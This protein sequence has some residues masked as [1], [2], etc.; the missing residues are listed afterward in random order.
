MYDRI[1]D[2]LAL[3]REPG[4]L[5]IHLYASSQDGDGCVGWGRDW[6]TVAGELELEAPVGDVYKSVVT[7]SD[8]RVGERAKAIENLNSSRPKQE[9]VNLVTGDSRAEKG[10]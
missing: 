8:L 1:H 6:A 5:A 2:V 7:D 4:V 3:W 9:W 10:G